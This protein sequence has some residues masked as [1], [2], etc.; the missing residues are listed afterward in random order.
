M[1]V[2]LENLSANTPDQSAPN[3]QPSSRTAAN[4]DQQNGSVD[5]DPRIERKKSALT[6]QSLLPSSNPPSRREILHDQNVRNDT[7]VVPERKPADG[8]KHGTLEGI[9]I[10]EQSSDSV[11]PIR[12]C[13]TVTTGINSQPAAMGCSPGMRMWGPCFETTG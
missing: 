9:A 2:L 11:R 7:L 12:V 4:H 8:G 6:H 1:D 10:M 13:I 3:K 5:I